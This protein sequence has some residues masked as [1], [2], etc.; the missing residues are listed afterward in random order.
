MKIIY[1][2]IWLIFLSPSVIFANGKIEAGLLFGS[3]QPSASSIWIKT[4]S[5][6]SRANLT[7]SKIIGYALIYRIIPSY[8]LRLQVDFSEQSLS[9]MKLKITAASLMGIFNLFQYPHY[10]IY[11][12]FGLID[13][14]IE[15]QI[16]RYGFGFPW[17]VV[18]PLGMSISPN[19]R[20]Y[21][22][23]EVQYIMG[24][25]TKL[26]NIT[27]KWDGLKFLLNLG[28]KL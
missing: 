10:R 28:I 22:K 20:C 24:A 25:N 9:P 14:Q 3:Y 4:D 11:T 5:K 2:L 13:Y 21:I 26:S 18:T 8:R 17:G 23:A 16:S 12:G 19:Q 1:I 7:H 15:N 27:Q 6:L